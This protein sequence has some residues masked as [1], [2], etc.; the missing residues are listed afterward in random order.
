MQF[1]KILSKKDLAEVKFESVEDF[2]A[3]GGFVKILKPYEPEVKVYF[4]KINKKQ[5]K[6]VMK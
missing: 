6:G 2:I 5:K 1:R 3:R 4:G